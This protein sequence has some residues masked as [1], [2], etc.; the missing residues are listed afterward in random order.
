MPGKSDQE[1]QAEKLY[2]QIKSAQ[3]SVQNRFE[4]YESPFDFEDMS[5]SL[6]DI[7][8]QYEDLIQR[9][10]SDL[11]SETQQD[12]VSSL[13]S[14]GI[15]GGSALTDTTSGI[16]S[17]IGKQ[18]FNALG[19]LGIGK[20]KGAMDLMNLFNQLDFNKTKAATDVDLANIS[21]MLSKFGVQGAALQGLDDST[22]LDDV[23]SGIST[24]A[25]ILAAPFTG[26]TSLLG[27][28]FS[29][30]GASA[31]GGG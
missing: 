17:K 26:G 13:A 7:F 19:E 6:D 20:S 15:T 28:L 14:R 18:K 25:P 27:A 4:G 3:T 5:G 11:I 8:Q 12:A 10:T 2:E 1:K 21:N 23:F 22:W 16:A 24:L 30:G 29:G 31:A 9:D